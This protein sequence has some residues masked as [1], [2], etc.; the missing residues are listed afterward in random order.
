MNGRMFYF[1]VLAAEVVSSFGA[2][3]GNSNRIRPL[4]DD[5]VGMVFAAGAYEEARLRVD[6]E[7]KLRPVEPLHQARSLFNPA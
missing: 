2:I 4:A 3:A 6:F 7:A 5:Y 1:A